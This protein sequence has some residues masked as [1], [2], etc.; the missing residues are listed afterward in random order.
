MES[1]IKVTELYYVTLSRWGI[2]VAEYYSSFV[3][4]GKD[5]KPFLPPFMTFAVCSHICLIDCKQYDPRTDCSLREQS[6]QG[7][8]TFC[9]HDESSL[10][11]L[12]TCSRCSK[13]KTFSA[14][15]GQN[16]WGGGGGGTL[17]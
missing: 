15:S 5:S 13:Q 12:N 11:C 4:G 14:F 10:E 9:F 1:C 7:S 17:N 6:D 16:I 2:R 8:N 3:V